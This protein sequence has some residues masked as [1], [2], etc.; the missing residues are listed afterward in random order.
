MHTLKQI[1][2]VVVLL[3][4]IAGMI[5]S[6]AGLYFAWAYNTP[7]TEAI[8]QTIGAAEQVLAAADNGLAT[9]NSGLTRAQG[10]VNTI[11]GATRSVGEL[12]NETDLA[13]AV[14]ERT[15]GETLFPRIESAQETVS[16][17]AQTIIGV[18]DALEAAN[19][20]P[21]VDLPTL[22]TELEAVSARLAE[23]RARVEEI[24]ATIQAIKEDKVARSV[25]FVTDRTEPLL[26][27]LG[28]A[29]A[30]VTDAQARITATLARLETLSQ[31]VPRLIDI[32]SISATLV[33]IWLFAVQGYLAL[34]LYEILSGK[35][36]NWD[37][38]TRRGEKAAAAEV[39]PS[40]DE[41][42]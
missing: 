13:F 11:D 35:K 8:V 27:Q 26:E 38:L 37:R 41:S 16:A 39:A 17:L 22:T 30:T 23:A 2:R 14:L 19:K 1:F 20:L 6:V 18:N 9:V 15:V 12:I 4:A 32:L 10:A 24:Q 34:R 3:I 29:L 42:A 5:L 21:F 36:I 40:V 28:G 31:R 7:A 33:M 25:S